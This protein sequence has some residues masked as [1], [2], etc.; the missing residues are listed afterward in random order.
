[1]SQLNPIDQGYR[2]R[3]EKAE[4]ET[5]YLKKTLEMERELY[6]NIR[7]LSKS[8][9]RNLNAL[10]EA[11]NMQI[12]L[13]R[14]LEAKIDRLNLSLITESKIIGNSSETRSN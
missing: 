4:A 6:V 10:K 1:M 5:E 9:D 8:R 7:E 13:V 12:D 2:E 14:A 11:Y 3:A